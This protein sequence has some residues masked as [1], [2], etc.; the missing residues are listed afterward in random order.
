VI[1]LTLIEYLLR[2][3][4]CALCAPQWGKDKTRGLI[5][6]LV[7]LSVCHISEVGL[8]IGAKVNVGFEQVL[9]DG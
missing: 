5:S 3:A 1:T 6:E 9:E 4:N 2:T 8:V 7:D